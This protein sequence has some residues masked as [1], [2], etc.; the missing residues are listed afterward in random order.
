VGAVAALPYGDGRVRR[1][2]VDSFFL[3]SARRY[4]ISFEL[5][6]LLS[7]LL[8]PL[9]QSLLLCLLALLALFF[10]RVRLAALA[11]LLGLGWLYLCST[12]VFADYLM[13]TLEDGYPPKALSV[14]E[15]ADAIVLLGGAI[16]GDV[17]LGTLGD[18][19]QQADRLVHAVSLYKAGK[20]PLLVVTGG[21]PSGARTEA[22][23]MYEL[24]QVMG[25]PAGAIVQEGKSRDTYQNAVYTAQMLKELGIRRILLVTSAFHMRRAQ[26]LFVAQGLEVV[27]APTD[28]Q[29][30]ASPP[31]MSPWMPSVSDLWQS[32]YALHELLGYQVYR[33][34]GRL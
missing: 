24:L 11:L 16:R 26:A 27:P 34:Q 4:T 3:T 14:V 9:S 31:L 21:G 25:V 10:H 13:G 32:T 20:S 17:H 22:Q 18:L 19:N 1:T 6:K 28:Y 30:L 23:I 8:Y 29:R 5:T 2:R 12:S 15:P 7:L 33:Y